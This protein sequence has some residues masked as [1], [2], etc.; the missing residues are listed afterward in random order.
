MKQVLSGP[1]LLS[2]IHSALRDAIRLCHLVNKRLKLFIFLPNP[3]MLDSDSGISTKHGFGNIMI[4]YKTTQPESLRDNSL[5]KAAVLLTVAVFL[6]SA[7]AP[8]SRVIAEMT[9]NLIVIAK[10]PAIEA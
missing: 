10:N 8:D 3:C 1:A 9:S 5:L 7:P 4:I 2:N 6:V